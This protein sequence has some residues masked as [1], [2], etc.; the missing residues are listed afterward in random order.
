MKTSVLFEGL[1]LS[2]V[3]VDW[4]CAQTAGG[5]PETIE[6]LTQ[7]RTQAQFC[8]DLLK[9][10]GDKAAIKPGQIAY[11]SAKAEADGVIAGLVTTLVEGGKP[12]SLPRVQSSL[13][14]A[15]AGLKEVCDGAVRTTAGTEGTKGVAEDIAKAAIEPVVNALVSG[16]GALWKQHVDKDALELATKKAQLEAA[17]WP[18]FGDVAPAQ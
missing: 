14:S 15:G 5:W 3:V 8:V 11:E 9:S 2:L 17:R 10:S 1:F 12:E 4:A 7:L 18:E 13:E 6:R 16:F